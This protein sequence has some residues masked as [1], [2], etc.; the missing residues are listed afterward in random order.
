MKIFN[1]DINDINAWLLR[2]CHT[3][4][5]NLKI[6]NIVDKS[7]SYL[8]NKYNKDIYGLSDWE[9]D[10][11][12]YLNKLN[13]QDYIELFKY[14]KELFIKNF[15]EEKWL[16]YYIKFTFGLLEDWENYSDIIN[17][18]KNINDILLKDYNSWFKYYAKNHKYE[19]WKPIAWV[20]K[21]L[22]KQINYLNH[23]DLYDFWENYKI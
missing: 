5:N 4:W 17:S 6:D 13:E 14:A 2:W 20:S 8:K 19:I 22:G 7:I 12:N 15:W 21:N 18:S 11:V 10:W 3:W 1:N 23:T 16:I 9:N